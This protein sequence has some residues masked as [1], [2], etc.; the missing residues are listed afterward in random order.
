MPRSDAERVPVEVEG[1]VLTLSS[2]DKVLFPA[3]RTTKGETLAYVAA[4]APALLAQLADRPVTRVRWPHGTD[5]ESFFEK[6]VPPGAPEWLPRVSLEAPSSRHGTERVTYP[7]IADLA[8]LTWVTNLG[9][10]ELHVPQWRVDASGERCAP[11]R[12][13]VDLDPGPG[14]G[15]RE[16]ARVALWAR[17]YL[18]GLGY[19]RTVPVTSG[20]KGMQLYAV[21]PAAVPA[22]GEGSPREVARAMA[23]ALQAAHPELVVSSMAKAKRAGKVL[24]DWSQN[25]PAKTTI[26]PYSLR[27]K[28]TTPYVAAPRPWSEVESGAEHGE[29]WQATPDEVVRRLQADGDLMAALTSGG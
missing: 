6:N 11:D 25:T 27:G 12:L 8:A 24:L 2:L 18:A 19:A 17:E 21:P 7:L 16:C 1:R 29:L 9:A 5:G 20:S 28:H 3:T 26:C 14:T 22:E 23:E 10:L 4:V 15:L 13:V